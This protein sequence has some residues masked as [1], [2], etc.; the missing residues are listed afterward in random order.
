MSQSPTLE[1]LALL[2]ADANV[3]KSFSF[4]L[5]PSYGACQHGAIGDCA[6]CLGRWP[7]TWQIVSPSRIWT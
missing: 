1:V 2:R 6:L 7:S 4:A 3:S 5:V